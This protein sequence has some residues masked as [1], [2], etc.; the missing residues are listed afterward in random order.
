[1]KKFFVVLSVAT[2]LA[3][4]DDSSSVSAENNEPTT[5]SSAEGQGSLSSSVMSGSDEPNSSSSS[6]KKTESS[7]SEK[8]SEPSSSSADKMESSSNS[9]F[10]AT[11]CK[12]ETEDNCEY[13]TVLD[14]RD[15]QTYKTVKI[16]DQW[17]MAENLNYQ[18]ENSWC[19]GGTSKTTLEGDCA[20]YGRLYTWAAATAACPQGW[21]LPTQ[22]E[23]DSL[24][25]AVGGL[26]VA[27][28]KLKSTSGWNSNGNGTDA[29]SFSA[30][31]AGNRDYNGGYGR[32]GDYAFF[33]S[34]TE[35]NSS[36]AYNMYL[37]YTY[38]SAVLYYSYKFDGFSVRCIRD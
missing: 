13:G 15:G 18:T 6:E 31:P 34:S 20:T 36:Y 23:W 35:Y 38:D 33:W 9:E 5:L 26:S 25:T 17:W 21:H 24:I 10:L 30:L 32:E 4:C 27:G 22:T 19:D 37:H 7:S 14:D 2:F 29:F 28:T 11:P 12:T 3:A 16:G 8:L 1:M